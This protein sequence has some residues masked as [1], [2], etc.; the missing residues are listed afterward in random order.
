MGLELESAHQQ[1][2]GGGI[3]MADGDDGGV[4]AR[5]KMLK[6]AENIFNTQHGQEVTMGGTG[7]WHRR[8]VMTIV[9]NHVC[10]GIFDQI[11]SAFAFFRLTS[12]KLIVV[13][14][15]NLRC[16]YQ[17]VSIVALL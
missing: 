12:K 6:S 11:C 4:R 2:C 5:M 9:G 8:G 13:G 10:F 15:G 14:L 17:E 7:G 3:L 16:Q 1:P